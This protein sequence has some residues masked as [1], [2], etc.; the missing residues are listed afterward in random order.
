MLSILKQN[1]GLICS[2]SKPDSE[3][4]AEEHQTSSEIDRRIYQEAKA[5]KHIQKLLLLG[6]GE[7]GKSTIFKQIRLL[8]QTGFDEQERR[9]YTSVIHA[10]VYQSIKVCSTGKD[11]V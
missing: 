9:T 7:S 11:F 2:K 8:F 3:A 1:M 5:D 10:N 6:A 4:N